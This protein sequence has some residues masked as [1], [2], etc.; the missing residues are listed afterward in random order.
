MQA[1]TTD[2][3]IVSRMIRAARLDKDVYEEVEHDRD[4]TGQAAMVVIGTSLAAGI[5][6]AISGG[7][8]GF[9]DAVL[10]LLVVATF[11]IIGWAVYAWVTYFIGTRFLAGPDTSAD[12]GEL[13]RTLGF[14]NSPRALMIFGIG[15]ALAGLMGLVV[16]IWILVTT[17]VALRA[18]LDFTTG[19]AIGTAL[20]GWVAQGIVLGIAFA[21]LA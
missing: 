19:R 15:P 18:A 21:L 14:A 11:S 2:R 12:W 1:A 10:G 6:A 17:V 16:G 5:G 9:G 3:S 20:L 13:A 7:S 4:A 8:D